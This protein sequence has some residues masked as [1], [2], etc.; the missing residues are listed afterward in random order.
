MDV[1]CSHLLENRDCTV[2]PGGRSRT[3]SKGP[4]KAS[5]KHRECA[6][7]EREKGRRGEGEGSGL[8]VVGRTSTDAQ[9]MWPKRKRSSDGATPAGR[10]L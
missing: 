2:Q 7:G 6:S 4:H 1:E 9:S 3:E 10:P 5:R 8:G